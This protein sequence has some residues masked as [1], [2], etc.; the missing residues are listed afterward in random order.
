MNQYNR[1]REIMKQLSNRTASVSNDTSGGMSKN[2]LVIFTGNN[3]EVETG[4][5]TLIAGRSYGFRYDLV[6]TEAAEALLDV[7]IIVQQ[8]Q[9]KRVFEET[10]NFYPEEIL[11]GIDS[12]VV[13]VPTQ[14]T[15]FKLALGIQDQLVPR[16]LWE[17]L[18]RGIPLWMNLDGLFLYKGKET[19]SSALKEVIRGHI[20]RLTDMGVKRIDNNHYLLEILKGKINPKEISVESMDSIDSIVRLDSFQWGDKNKSQ[21]VV[22]T[23][24]DILNYP[25]GEKE[26]QVEENAII[27]SLA[28]DAAKARGIKLIKIKAPK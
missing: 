8:L 20:T 2:I 21:R 23:E 11:K 5:K 14:N 16:L 13:P 22:I 9:P 10:K 6:F 4:I 24:R 19:T 25:I 27:T 17:G 7:G 3:H 18:W 1:T 26:I 15:A 12:I 28:H